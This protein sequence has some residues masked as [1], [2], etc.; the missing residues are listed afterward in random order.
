MGGKILL[1]DDDELILLTTG[2]YLTQEG[3]EVETAESGEDAIEKLD[4]NSSYDLVVTDLRMYGETGVDVFKK[5]LD[6]NANIPVLIM[7]GFGG[8]TPM[9]K[10]AMELKPCSYAFKP[11]SEEELLEK[12]RKCLERYC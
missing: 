2:E 3:F 9:F 4:K 5:V 8:E 6:V 1:V 11:F 7:T 12:V 10:E